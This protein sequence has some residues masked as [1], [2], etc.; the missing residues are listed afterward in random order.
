MLQE[1]SNNQNGLRVFFIQSES[2][3]IWPDRRPVSCIKV[4]IRYTFI[5]SNNTV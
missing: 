5:M 3:G 1:T 2:K 4:E